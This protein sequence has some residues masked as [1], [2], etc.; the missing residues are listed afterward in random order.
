[1]VIK[2][3]DPDPESMNPDPQHK[4]HKG[5][6]S[7]DLPFKCLYCTN[8]FK[9]HE[10]FFQLLILSSEV[11]KGD[12]DLPDPQ[13]TVP[14]ICQVPELYAQL[15][16]SIAIIEEA[17]SQCIRHTLLKFTPEYYQRHYFQLPPTCQNL[18]RQW[19][20]GGSRGG[21]GGVESCWRPYSAA[22]LHSNLQ[23]CLPTPRQKLGGERASNR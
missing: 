18:C 7:K 19:L 20:G 11:I 16:A 12:K 14:T 15:T 3:L 6:H 17:R 13:Q 22:V 1:M 2:S 21:G 9:T 8:P 23:N 5:V 4:I 10:S